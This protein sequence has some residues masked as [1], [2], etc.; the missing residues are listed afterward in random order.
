MNKAYDPNA[1]EDDM[2]ERAEESERM[3]EHVLKE[4]DINKDRL[5]AFDE[6]LSQTKKDEFNRSDETWDGVDDITDDFSDEE[7]N[8]FEHERQVEIQAMLDKGQVPPGYPYFGDVPVGGAP[9]QLPQQVVPGSIPGQAAYDPKVP[10]GGRPPL[11]MH[12]SLP[13]QAAYPNDQAPNVV[14]SQRDSALNIPGFQQHAPIQQNDQ[15]VQQDNQ[16]PP[17]QQ[18]YQQLPQAQQPQEFQQAPQSKSSRNE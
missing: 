1:P 6:F 15:G 5:I 11:T 12:G 3:R 16:Q 13:G 17:L 18:Q 2:R 4:M 10:D 14:P 8:Q 7:F 9:Y